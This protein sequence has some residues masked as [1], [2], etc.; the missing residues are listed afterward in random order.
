MDSSLKLVAVVIGA[1]ALLVT[2]GG[3]V[4]WVVRKSVTA[5]VDQN[6][7]LVDTYV[8]SSQNQ[9]EATN[10]NTEAT[11]ALAAT[12]N[13]SIAINNERDRTMFKQLDRIERQHDRRHD[14]VMGGA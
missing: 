13:Q 1:I 10:A 11:R 6:K 9:V 5:I 2:G 14:D 12:L 4:L 8:T 7:T 3:G